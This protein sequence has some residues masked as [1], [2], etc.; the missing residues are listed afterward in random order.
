[1]CKKISLKTS[2]VRFLSL[3]TAL[4]VMWQLIEISIPFHTCVH[5]TL[6]FWINRIPENLS[7]F[8]G[9]FTLC[10]NW[11]KIKHGKTLKSYT[12]ARWQVMEISVLFHSCVHLTLPF[13]IKRIPENFSSFPGNF[14]LGTKMVKN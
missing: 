7:S 11:P 14:A 8:P 6:P 3:T 9:K 5:V 12:L 1:M 10:K 13:W 4:V 2:L